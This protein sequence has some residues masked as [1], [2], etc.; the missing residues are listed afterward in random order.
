MTRACVD[1]AAQDLYF[2]RRSRCPA[3]LRKWL[4]RESINVEHV[5]QKDRDASDSHHLGTYGA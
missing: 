1:M 3:R 4:A 5:F 2:E